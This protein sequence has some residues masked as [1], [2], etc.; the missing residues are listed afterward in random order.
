MLEVVEDLQ[1][2]AVARTVADRER[3]DDTELDLA[4]HAERDR[5]LALYPGQVLVT[6]RRQVEVEL[7]R[8]ARVE[9]ALPVELDDERRRVAR[10]WRRPRTRT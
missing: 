3:H 7:H 2:A 6:E 10:P 9:V 1:R 5:A 4:A 8:R